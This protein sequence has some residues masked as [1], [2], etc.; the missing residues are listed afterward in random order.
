MKLTVNNFSEI[1]I[2]CDEKTKE[3]I[4][5]VT[6]F[7]NPEYE[8]KLKLG[9]YVKN[10]PKTYTLAKRLSDGVLVSSSWLFSSQYNNT[11]GE[12]FD[13]EKVT[14]YTKSKTSQKFKAGTSIVLRT[15]QTA[16]VRAVLDQYTKHNFVRGIIQG[17]TGS[18]KTITGVST[19]LELGYKTLWLTHKVELLD[20]AYLAFKNLTG[21]SIARVGGGYKDSYEGKQ[22]IVATY[23]SLI[24]NTKLMEYINQKMDTLVIDECHHVPSKYFLGAL[25]ALNK[26]K[27]VI[28]LTATPERKDGLK[29]MMLF[30]I[31]PILHKM[32]K[33]QMEEHLVFPKV[34]YHIL[35]Y[36]YYGMS[37]NEMSYITM[38]N[39]LVRQ[40]ERVEYTLGVIKSE[41]M[42]HFSLILTEYVALGEMYYNALKDVP[43]L[44][45]VQY[46]ARLPKK[47]KEQLMRDIKN[48][49][50]NVIIATN[51]AREGLDIPHLDRLFLV[52]PKKGD[53]DNKTPDGTGVEQEVGR[54]MRTCEGKTEA[55]VYDFIDKN[56]DMFQRQWYT[57][58][59]TYDRIKLKFV[60]VDV[61]KEEEQGFFDPNFKI[62][63]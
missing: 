17:T 33:S 48:K 49:K 42:G 62:T 4:I 6:T 31:G 60:K 3:R 22:V 30:H 28:G 21:V 15:Y 7:D 56:I 19:V 9:L 32:N 41:A 53:R 12:D 59:K 44:K 63:L 51:I 40:P 29:P 14:I 57:R 26:V 23:Q 58:K 61:T 2:P 27:N 5:R 20:Q 10:T 25:I 43:G 47:Q 45:V 18:G 16:A 11:I 50:Y 52:T 24:K 39:E 1:F 36:N 8:N 54:I 46:N 37:A 35:R 38:V 55:I 13:L 34:Q